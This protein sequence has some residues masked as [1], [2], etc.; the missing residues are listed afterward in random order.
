M[1]RLLLGIILAPL[2][3][4]GSIALLSQVG[5]K[6][7]T[8][9][10]RLTVQIE[11]DG[12]VKT[13]SSVIEVRKT[14]RKDVIIGYSRN[15]H[16]SAEGEAVHI[17]LG[18]GRHVFAL[19]MTEGSAEHRRGRDAFRYGLE[20]LAAEVFFRSGIDTDQLE[21]HKKAKRATIGGKTRLEFMA[22]RDLHDPKTAYIVEPSDFSRSLGPDINY[23]GSWIDIT[24][25]P[26]THTLETTL[27][28]LPQ[29]LAQQRQRG[30]V[31]RRTGEFSLSYGLFKWSHR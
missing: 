2:L 9:R 3:L 24:N 25:D 29:L 16:L 4:I 1:N 18:R 27:S 15:P 7:T 23:I 13:G 19:A 8:Y 31:I 14:D 12:Q 30:G 22:F 10:Y 6:H 17:D 5:L 28:W 21:W 11:A 20:S 26:V